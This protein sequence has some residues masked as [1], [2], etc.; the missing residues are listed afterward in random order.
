MRRVARGETGGGMNQRETLTPTRVLIVI[1][2]FTLSAAF[3]YRTLTQNRV[4]SDALWHIRTGEYI[5]EHR[6]IPASD[7]FSWYGKQESL[8]WL[9]HEWLFDIGIYGAWSLGGFRLIYLLTALIVG[10]VAPAVFALTRARTDEF[11]TSL[12]AGVLAVL[13]CARFIAPRPQVLTFALIVA[14]A[15]LLERRRWFWAVATMVLAVN[16]HG[17]MYPMYLLVFAFYCIPRKSIVLLAAG[18]AVLAQPLTLQLLP[19]PFFAFDSQMAWFQEAAPTVL[20]RDWLYLPVLIGL[21]ALTHRRRVPLQVA[22]ASLA[23]IVLGLN[24]ARHTAFTYLLVIPMIAPFI[25]A[26]SEP[27]PKDAEGAASETTPHGLSSTQRPGMPAWVDRALVVVLLASTLFVV[28]QSWSKHIDYHAEYPKSAVDY[29]KEQGITR[30]W[31]DWGDG[32]YLIFRGVET[33]VDGRA[34]PFSPFFR[35]D[36]TLAR[37]FGITWYVGAD[38]RRFLDKYGVTH[39]LIAKRAPLYQVVSQSRDFKLAYAD[40]DY[41]VYEYSGVIS[42]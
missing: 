32:G 36:V 38:I 20:A 29:V 4:D 26:P 31:N 14:L 41:A 15:L 33:L 23:L 18:L 39:M 6:E 37:D 2:L 13:G 34:D 11:V 3:A 30:I 24:G 5:V 21:V 1:L 22:I 35:K 8:P 7:V 27:R 12:I 16:L 25:S 40:D 19:Y 17:G 10:T 42:P 28:S 9:P